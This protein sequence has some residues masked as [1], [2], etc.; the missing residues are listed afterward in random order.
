MLIGYMYVALD[1]QD[2]SVGPPTV[3]ARADGQFD[4]TF[5]HYPPEGTKTVQVAVSFNKDYSPVQ[6]LD[7]PDATGFFTTTVA[8]YM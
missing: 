1:N 4:V 5:R 8:I 3:V 2:L 7:G 6:E